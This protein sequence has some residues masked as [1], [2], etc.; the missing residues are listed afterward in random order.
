M[1][2]CI[3]VKHVDRQR[4]G[5]EPDSFDHSAKFRFCGVPNLRSA[6]NSEV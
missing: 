1:R 5:T 2:I 6:A 3:T 4:D